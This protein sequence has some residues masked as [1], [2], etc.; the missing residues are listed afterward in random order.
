MCQVIAKRF[1]LWLDESGDFENDKD[2]MK[3]PSLV[4]GILVEKNSSDISGM[5]DIIGSDQIH[6]NEIKGPG[7]SEYALD[8]LEKIR[9]KGGE[10]VIFENAERLEIVNSTRTYLNIISEGII[11]LI[12]LLSASYESVELNV[13]VA[14]RKQ[15]EIQ[16]TIK[17]GIILYPE[18]ISRMEEK[19]IIGLARRQISNV[20]NWKWS[21]ELKSAR[22]D[23]RLMLADIACNTWLTRTSRK[24]NNPQKEEIDRLYKSQYRFTVFEE[25]ASSHIKRL[26]A[27]G[28]LAEAIFEFYTAKV[29]DVTNN[30]LDIILS[31]LKTLGSEGRHL[32]LLILKSKIGQLVS[33][34]KDFATA[35]QLIAK[36][37]EDFIINMEDLE[38][39][40]GIFALDI[41][42]YFLT[43]CTHEGDIKEAQK[44]SLICESVMKNLAG[45][46]ESIDYFF[47]YKTRLAVHK[48]NSFDFLG[49]HNEM[50]K[51]IKAL[52]ETMELF[53]VIDELDELYSDLKSDILGKALGTRL[54]ATGKMLRYNKKMY[55]QAIADSDNALKEFT[56][57]GD[58]SR[59]YQYRAQ[60]ECEVGNYIEA[61][62]NLF[63]ANNITYKGSDS[64]NEF[65]RDLTMTHPRVQSFCM[66]HYTKI[67]SE[68]AIT[69][70]SELADLL[71]DSLLKHQDLYNNLVRTDR[72]DHP[73]EIIKWKLATYQGLKGNISSATNLYDQAIGMCFERPERWTFL[74]I[75]LGILAEKASLLYLAS[76]KHAKEAR[77][78]F[79][80]LNRRYDEFISL[81]LPEPMREYFLIWENNLTRIK[82]SDDPVFKQE[83]LWELSRQVTY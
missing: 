67:M 54:Q 39:R 33:V 78:T 15:M 77:K 53:S 61:L 3:N 80:E 65:L 79:R 38:L 50:G 20:A 81:D 57:S 23:P 66:L 60:I 10:I 76:N 14:V 74:A 58:I 34:N 72:V 24:F 32:Q 51:I 9:Q 59:Q 31:R 45:R 6:M 17:H 28:D 55:S 43:V 47:M 70:E 83:G 7:A 19:I 4:G 8:V 13:I 11:K 46:W 52:S 40:P 44:Q 36:I 22:T 30:L 73:Y 63:K 68:A 35:K 64:I 56:R 16:D 75:G 62:T 18:Y 82:E 2:M 69:D 42:L 21:I 5:I 49:A 48:I 37:Q 1:E 25:V 41:S 71:Y 12:Q 27:E 29:G 26:I